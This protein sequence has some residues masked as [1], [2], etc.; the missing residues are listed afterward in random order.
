MGSI[1]S[2]FWRDKC[3]TTS[4]TPN[5]MSLLPKHKILPPQQVK[6]LSIKQKEQL[7][8]YKFDSFY[9]KMNH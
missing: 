6:I 5:S 7:A 2:M 4:L 3:Q 8:G 9:D 1:T